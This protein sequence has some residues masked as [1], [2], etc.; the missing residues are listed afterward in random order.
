MSALIDWA[1]TNNLPMWAIV[2]QCEG[3]DIWEYLAEVWQAMDAAIQRG[4][5]AE[6]ILPGGLNLPRKARA[7]RSAGR[8][9]PDNRSARLCAYALAVAEENASGHKVVTAPTCGSCAVLP[10]VLNFYGFDKGDERLRLEAL[11]I[12][13]LVGNMVKTNA[14]ISGAQVGCQGEVGTAC[15]MAAAAGAYLMG[16]TDMQ[17]EYA[18]EMGLEHHLGLTCDPVAGLVQIPCIERNAMAA[19]R[20]IDCAEFAMLGDGRHI[21]SFDDVVNVMNQT[22]H[23][24]PHI[25]RET[26]LGGLANIHRDCPPSDASKH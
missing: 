12:A 2:E 1:D 3:T 18:A 15:S 26:A 4:L 9:L 7:Y 25:Y 13:G 23:D 14:S 10:A 11:A 24:L 20:A 5:G 21:I 16:A 17:I 22:G 8:R 6:G 19:M